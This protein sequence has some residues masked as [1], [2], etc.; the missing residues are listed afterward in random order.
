MSFLSVLKEE[1][2]FQILF[3]LSK[4]YKKGGMLEHQFHLNKQ[5]KDC[6]VWS[7]YSIRSDREA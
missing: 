7:K 1:C 2:A 6:M 3:T 4:I 5:E